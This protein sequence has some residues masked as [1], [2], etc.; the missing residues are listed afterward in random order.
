M[1]APKTPEKTRLFII[2]I[3]NHLYKT[4]GKKP[5]APRVLEAAQKSIDH[6][7]RKD[8]FLPKIRKTEQI[9]KEI[10]PIESLSNEERA[11]QLDWKLTS[12]YPLHPASMPAV[13]RVWKY[14][15][16]VDEKFTVR[17]AKWVSK[18]CGSRPETVPLWTCAYLYSKKEE[19][20]L[21]SQISYDSFYDDLSIF[22]DTLELQTFL[23][24]HE[25]IKSIQDEFGMAYPINYHDMIVEEVLHP[26]DYYNSLING[27]ISNLRDQELIALTFKLPSLLE[28]K[29]TQIA[30]MLYVSWFAF[31]RKTQDWS[32]ITAKHAVD[33]I[34]ELRS[35]IIKLQP[36]LEIDSKV[37]TFHV[38]L[39]SKP[40]IVTFNQELLRPEMA[41][42]L[43]SEYAKGGK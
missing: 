33:V 36:I 26:L 16:H 8:I 34:N 31:I 4:Y 30:Y 40:Q 39:Q 6:N 35:W 28:L 21:M 41:L 5:S 14:S 11:Q 32:V 3:Y 38:E 20:C 12:D 37:R 22:M 27:S 23:E 19:L 9:I 10:T 7:E 2:D 25:N 43:L 15:C 42:R 29:L 17:Q 13:V 1:G 24:T 18:L